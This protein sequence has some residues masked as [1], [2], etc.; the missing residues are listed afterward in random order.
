MYE[1]I[2]NSS[3]GLQV[4]GGLLIALTLV[5]H[6]CF[7]L[8][9]VGD[10]SRRNDRGMHVAFVGPGLWG[11]ATFGTGMIAVGLYWLMHYSSL[12]RGSDGHPDDQLKNPPSD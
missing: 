8:A 3:E 12:A 5:T 10:A 7:G 1:L 4:L 2:S 11:I 9:I 6:V